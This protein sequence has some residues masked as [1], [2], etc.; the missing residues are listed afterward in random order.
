MIFLSVKV[1]GLTWMALQSKLVSSR[2][3]AWQ[4]NFIQEMTCWFNASKLNHSFHKSSCMEFFN[5]KS[6]FNFVFSKVEN[7][8]NF[9]WVNFL[10]DSPFTLCFSRMVIERTIILE[11][12]DV[13]VL[14]YLIVEFSILHNDRI[15]SF[16]SRLAGFLLICLEELN[17]FLMSFTLS[18]F[19]RSIASFICWS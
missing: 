13:G 14:S 18:I 11:F 6:S 2:N 16:S 1:E 10:L 19:K 9:I 7:Q 8:I 17:S 4:S 15:E 3:L 5:N 12:N